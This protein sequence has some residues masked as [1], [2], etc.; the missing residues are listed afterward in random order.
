MEATAKRWL[1]ISGQI[2]VDKAGRVAAGAEAQM[3]ECW[4]HIFE[5]LKS[6][7]MT[8]RNLVKITGY[9]TD[10]TDVS[11]FRQVRDGLL[12]GHEPASTLVVVAA[13]AHPDWRVEIEA[14]AAA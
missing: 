5:I 10:P 2:G 4:H 9:V 11:A 7:G 8:K 3:R 6:A 13:L 1:H 14:I 12:E